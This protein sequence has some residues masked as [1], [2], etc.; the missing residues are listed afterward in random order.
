M[1]PVTSVLFEALLIGICLFSVEKGMTKFI[2]KGAGN[3]IIAG[4]LVHLIF[5]YSPLGNLN[6]KWCKIIFENDIDSIK[7]L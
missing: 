3:L 4:A 6:E 7:N 1:R 5:E 2:Y